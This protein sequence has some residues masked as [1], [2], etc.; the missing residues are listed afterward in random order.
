MIYKMRMG[1]L[2][3][4]NL[5]PLG[6]SFKELSNQIKIFIGQ[7]LCQHFNPFLRMRT[8]LT[9]SIQEIGFLYLIPFNIISRLSRICACITSL[10]N[11]V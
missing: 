2:I 10:I 5:V 1:D 8:I 3:E 4:I 9:L 6:F 11:L 7:K